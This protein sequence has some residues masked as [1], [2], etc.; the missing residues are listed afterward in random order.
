MSLKERSR[1]LMILEK[2]RRDFVNRAAEYEMVTGLQLSGISI[3]RH[4][5]DYIIEGQETPVVPQMMA[6]NSDL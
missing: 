3:F 4:G 6:V 1:K 5:D 2:I